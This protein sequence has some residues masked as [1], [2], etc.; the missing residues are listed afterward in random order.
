MRDGLGPVWVVNH[1]GGRDQCRALPP[2][3][4]SE[5]I[6]GATILRWNPSVGT[7]YAHDCG[8]ECLVSDPL[9]DGRLELICDCGLSPV[10]LAVQFRVPISRLHPGD[11]DVSRTMIAE[12]AGEDPDALALLDVLDAP[13]LRTVR[14]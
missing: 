10:E 12:R 11:L 5:V 14:R 7:T 9:G 4:P 13:P 8:G 1:V 3:K 2:P 6:P